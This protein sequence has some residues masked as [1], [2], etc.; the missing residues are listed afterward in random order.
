MGSKSPI[1]YPPLGEGGGG[2]AGVVR[3]WGGGGLGEKSRQ[4]NY[5]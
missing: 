2:G 1:T 3:P 4:S 5:R